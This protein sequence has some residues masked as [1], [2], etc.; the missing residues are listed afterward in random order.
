MI[1]IGACIVKQPNELYCR[2]SNVV[3]CP[4]HYNMTKEEYL[5]NV[6]G[7]VKDR[8]DGLDTLNNYLYPFEYILDRFMPMNMTQEEFNEIVIEMS[9]KPKQEGCIL[10]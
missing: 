3:E 8:E 5:S 1:I 7:T 2:F 9:E 6:T 10:T 4:T